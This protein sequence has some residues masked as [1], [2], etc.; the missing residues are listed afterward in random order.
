MRKAEAVHERENAL[1]DG[2]LILQID[3]AKV[4]E[5]KV[6][7]SEVDILSTNALKALSNL[8]GRLHAL[9]VSEVDLLDIVQGIQV[10]ARCAIL[11]LN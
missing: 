10:D 11:L 6:E 1:G 2:Q 3:G 9:G 5:A 4:Q 8:H 7:G